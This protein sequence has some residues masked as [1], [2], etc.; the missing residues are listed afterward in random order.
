MQG[1]FEKVILAA[2][3][4]A[5]ASVAI[6]F[7]PRVFWKM[8]ISRPPPILRGVNG[9]DWDSDR[10]FTAA[11]FERHPQTRTEDGLLHELS[12]ED[13]RIDRKHRSAMYNWTDPRCENSLYLDWQASRVGR[14]VSITH[15]LQ[16]GC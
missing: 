3:C 8:F 5:L 10:A 12:S 1:A 7:S 6:I 16:A 4:I 2:G 14:V 11:I 13:F 15:S 9:P